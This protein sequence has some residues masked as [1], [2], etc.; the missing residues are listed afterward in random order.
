M[1]FIAI[2]SFECLYFIV[3]GLPCLFRID[4]FARK[5]TIP[6]P[7][8]PH[9]RRVPKQVIPRSLFSWDSPHARL[10][11]FTGLGRFSITS[12]RVRKQGGSRNL[13]SLSRSRESPGISWAVGPH[14]NLTLNGGISCNF[15]KFLAFQLV[16]IMATGRTRAQ[17]LNFRHRSVSQ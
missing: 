1:K 6:R 2:I 17:G 3:Y 13:E 5:Y 4:K 12:G 9:S 14:C 15:V 16:E 11:L 8:S 7:A 10:D